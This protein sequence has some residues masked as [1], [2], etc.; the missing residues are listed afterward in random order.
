MKK[1]KIE[2]KNLVITWTPGQYNTMDQ[3]VITHSDDVGNAV[4]QRKTAKGLVD[5]F[6][7]IPY[8]FAFRAFYP[9]GT[10][11]MK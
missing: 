1:K 7:D 8:A 2:Y 10:I 5:V 4:V 11:F 6:Y 9:K 3:S